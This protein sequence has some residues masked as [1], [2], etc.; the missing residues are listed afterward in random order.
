[1]ISFLLLTLDFICL[2]LV[3]DVR[4]SSL[5][6]LFFLEVRFAINFAINFPVRTVFAASHNFGL[7]CLH[8]HL[9]QGIF[10]FLLDS[11]SNPLII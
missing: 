11:F 3:S 6:F 5:R 1:M 9:S 8:C 7:L 10:F 4:I 2:S